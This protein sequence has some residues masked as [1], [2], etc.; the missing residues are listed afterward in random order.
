MNAHKL[1]LV[2]MARTAVGGVRLCNDLKPVPSC[3]FS[4]HKMPFGWCGVRRSTMFCRTENL[5]HSR[6]ESVRFLTKNKC[7]LSFFRIYLV[8]KQ[9]WWRCGHKT[10]AN[11]LISLQRKLWQRNSNKKKNEPNRSRGHHTF[12][13][14]ENRGS[15]P[16]ARRAT[17]ISHK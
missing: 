2:G 9:W 6:N 17:V 11:F 10:I 16:G 13:V 3:Y 15:R 1:F 5:F 7:D 4:L 12:S 8:A 14:G